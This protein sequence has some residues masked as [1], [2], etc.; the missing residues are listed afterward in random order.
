MDFKKEDILK[1]ISLSRLSPEK[2]N[3]D[4][5]TKNFQ[6]IINYV[7]Q[8]NEVDVTNIEPLA[9]VHEVYNVFRKD[10]ATNSLSPEEG[11]ANVK[12]KSGN[13]IKVPLIIE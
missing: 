6:N 9:H 3:I 12:E 8:L 10:I 4:A 13:Y 1:I 7:E 5:V 2:E 11:L